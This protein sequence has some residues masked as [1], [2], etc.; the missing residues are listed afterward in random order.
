M[1]EELACFA[2]RNAGTTSVTGLRSTGEFV[3]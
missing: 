3:L 2:R 1:I